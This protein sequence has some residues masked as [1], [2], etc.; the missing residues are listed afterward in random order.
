MDVDLEAT[1]IDADKYLAGLHGRP[2]GD[3]C[4]DLGVTDLFGARARDVDDGGDGMA[5]LT[6]SSN[7]ILMTVG[8][9]SST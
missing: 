4:K 7:T 3:D 6:P 2:R 1:S 5:T 9:P 8:T